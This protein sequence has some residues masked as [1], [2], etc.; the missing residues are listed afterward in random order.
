MDK[1]KIEWADALLP[2]TGADAMRKEFPD[3][4]VKRG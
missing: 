3:W 2:I 1:T 4:L